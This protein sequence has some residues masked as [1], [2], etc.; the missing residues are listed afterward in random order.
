MDRAIGKLTPQQQKEWQMY[1]NA[2][3]EEEEALKA[4]KQKEK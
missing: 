2:L 1:L 4:K 3:K